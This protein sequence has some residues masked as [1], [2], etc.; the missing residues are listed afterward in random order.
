MRRVLVTG[1][2][3]FLGSTLMDRLARTPD[4][5]ALGLD[6]RQPRV[7]WEAPHVRFAQV[8]LR[9]A[10]ALDALVA[11]FRPTAVVHLASIVEPPP[12][13]TR[14]EMRA[15]DVGGTESVLRCC[16]AYEV[17]HLTVTTSGAAYGYHPD[18]PPWIDEDVP[19]RGNPEFAYSDH[20]RQIEELLAR[21][22]GEHPE[23]RQLVLR[24]GT[25]LGRTVGNQIT[26]L[27]ARPAVLGV[28][29]YDSPFVFIWD[30]DVCEIIVRGVLE[31][32]VGCYNLAGDDAMSLREIAGALGK[33][34]VSVPAWLLRAALR[35]L[36]PLGAV[37]Y[38]PEQVMFLQH[39][40]VLSNARL[41][42]DF[43]YR[44]RYS[45]AE[46]FTELLRA[47]PHLRASP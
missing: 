45:S 44:P 41:K 27:F 43:P 31:E 22:R 36:H 23:L 46:A 14:A 24:P 3:G 37:P 35:V 40:P 2:S 32:V 29:G 17:R 11:S 19:I 33:P 42:R 13:M 39:R 6:V 5:E 9:D 1:A 16:L 7:P 34:Y 30:E 28:S 4:C 10:S 15:I 47:Q 21:A 20:K 12:G 25:I 18:N 26:A 8:D 38:G